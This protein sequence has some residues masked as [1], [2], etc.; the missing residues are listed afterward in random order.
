MKCNGVFFESL[1]QPFGLALVSF[2]PTGPNLVWT[3]VYAPVSVPQ[4]QPPIVYVYQIS[5]H[6]DKFQVLDVCGGLIY[7]L[8]MLPVYSISCT[9]CEVQAVL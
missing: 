4:F 1:V 5:E 7:S 8:C 2:C 6:C 9:S 3:Y